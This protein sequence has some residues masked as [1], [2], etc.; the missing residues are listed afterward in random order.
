MKALILCLVATV[1]QADSHPACAPHDAQIAYLT[2][3]FGETVQASGVTDRQQFMELL[4]NRK[5]DTWT[6]VLTAPD[7]TAC[8]MTAGGLLMQTPPGDPA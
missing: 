4:G 3:A 6:L 7:G 2:A 1:A 5:T 8:M